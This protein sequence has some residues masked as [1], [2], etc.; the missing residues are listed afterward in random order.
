MPVH[1]I[2]AGEGIVGDSK[3]DDMAVHC[4]DVHMT[5]VRRWVRKGIRARITVTA[6]DNGSRRSCEGAGTP[7]ISALHDES[8]LPGQLEVVE[9]EW[10]GTEPSEE[11]IVK[12]VAVGIRPTRRAPAMNRRIR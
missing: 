8:S 6:L 12:C 11:S 1:G 9:W 10:T 4:G 2:V 3:A 7:L 5:A